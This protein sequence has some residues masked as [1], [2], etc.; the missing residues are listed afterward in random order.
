MLVYRISKRAYA[1]DLSGTGAGLYGGRWNPKGVNLVYTAASTSLACLEYLVHNIHLM[2]MNELCLSELQ[3]SDDSSIEVLPLN[4]LPPDWQ[5][6]AYTP[7]S[8]QKIGLD[9]FQRAEAYLLKV[10]S[11]IVSNEFNYLLNPLH[12]DHK[13]TSVHQQITP[14]TIDE[15]LFQL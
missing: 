12:P 2:G 7:L 1:N 10:P 15:R 5:S 14:F 11:A 4:D 13:Q 9:F 3:I 6:K 8:T